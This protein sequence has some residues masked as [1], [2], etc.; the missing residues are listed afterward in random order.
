[1][2]STTRRNEPAQEINKNQRGPASSRTILGD[3][4]NTTNIIDNRDGSKKTNQGPRSA[5]VELKPYMDRPVDDIDSKDAANP[6]LASTYVND[7]YLVFHDQEREFKVNWEYMRNQNFVND[8]MRCILV[9]WL[10]SIFT[11]M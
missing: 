1:M 5:P 3:I 9:D 7:M 10:V 8:K 11:S 6:A 2:R 4:T